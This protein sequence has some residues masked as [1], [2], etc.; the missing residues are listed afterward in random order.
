MALVSGSSSFRPS[1]DG[2]N[3]AVFA[4]T[5]A[6]HRAGFIWPE[7]SE[8]LLRGTS[9]VIEEKLGSGRVVLFA[10]NPMFRGWWRSMDKLVLNAILLGG[11]F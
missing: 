2:S 8:R 11:A 10:N 1:R 7:N 5:G 4:T 9:L 3:V 6:L